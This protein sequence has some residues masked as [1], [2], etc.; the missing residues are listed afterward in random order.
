MNEKNVTRIVQVNKYFK[1]QLVAYGPVL[2]SSGY[3]RRLRFK[4]LS[5]QIPALD[6]VWTFFTLNCRKICI[7]G[8]KGPKMA[9][10]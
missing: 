6:T 7:V 8:F 1:K 3:G 9:R 5:V 2:W 10:I 4:K